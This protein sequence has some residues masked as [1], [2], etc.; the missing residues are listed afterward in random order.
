MGLDDFLWDLY[1]LTRRKKY[2]KTRLDFKVLRTP[3]PKLLAITIGAWNEATVIGD[4]IENLITSIQYPKSMYHLFVGVYPNDQE[5]IDVVK[6]I[7][8]KYP[9][10]HMV[11]NEIPGPTTKAQNINYVIKNIKNMK[12]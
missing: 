2:K 8:K 7:E 5:T 12:N 9:N 1:S 3:P 11:I 10:V 4:V 6:E